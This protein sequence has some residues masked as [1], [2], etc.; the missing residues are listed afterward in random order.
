MLSGLYEIRYLL[1]AV[2]QEISQKQKESI[3]KVLQDLV[4]S[5]FNS[6]RRS[7][8]ITACFFFTTS[9]C[10]RILTEIFDATFQVFYH[11]FGHVPA[12]SMTYQYALYHHILAIGR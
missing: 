3:P 4:Y 9:F 5:L 7:M 8:V 2:R 1:A 12:E 11:Q 10:D 6:G